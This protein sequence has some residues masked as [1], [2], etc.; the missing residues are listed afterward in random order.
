VKPPPYLEERSPHFFVEVAATAV[1]WGL[2]AYFIAP[3]LSLL[4]WAGGVHVFVEEMITLG[5]YE[6]LL[7]KLIAY[8]L[9]V[10][11]IVVAVNA[12]VLWNVRRYGG[13]NTRTHEL[14]AVTLVESADAAGMAEG[15]LQRCQNA[16]RVLVEFDD[17][18][19]M[20]VREWR[21][22]RKGSGRVPGER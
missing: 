7:E 8:G 4:L 10:L 17:G 19:R 1:F 6:A 21:E 3:L 20:Q 16:K 12:W 5:G 15:E 2:W 13:H 9:V 18:N 14:A 11:A 22:P